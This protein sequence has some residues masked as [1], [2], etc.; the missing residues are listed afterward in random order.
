MTNQHQ[1]L[2]LGRETNGEKLRDGLVQEAPP[3]K[4]LSQ[5]TAGIAPMLSDL[6]TVIGGQAGVLLK[7]AESDATAQEPLQQICA[8]ADKAGSLLRQLQIFSGQQTA[9]VENTQL[10]GLI[11]ENVGGLHRLLG[12]GMTV[13][14]HLAD[15]LPTVEIDRT[16]LEQLLLILTLNAV[17]AMP[18]GGRL[19]IQTEALNIT[20]LVAKDHPGSRP[21]QFVVLS[22]Q[23]SG[24]GIAPE[25]LPRIFE[26]FFTT[27]PVGRSVGLGLAT[28]SGIV[29]LHQGWIEV[30]NT[31]DG[32]TRFQVMLPA[33][34][35]TAAL[36]TRLPEAT[37]QSS[38]NLTVLLV[39]DEAPVREFAAFVL[40]GQGCRVLQAV[41]GLDALEVWQ[42]HGSR[43]RLLLTDVVLED[44]MNG[45]ELAIN[46]R[47]ENPDLK[48]ICTT[49]LQREE[50]E[51]FP[52][53][54][55]G[56]HYLQKPYRFETLVMALR[57]ALEGT[58]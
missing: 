3:M 10:N 7:S 41:S 27:K 45:M 18:V 28:A 11:E 44:D 23:D 56:Y 1:S 43:I 49:G 36:K 4:A 39:E 31:H 47:A 32:G 34:Q 29:R 33:A 52:E 58:V 46:L 53:L 2:P 5:I 30:K 35:A 40:R 42:W 38:G 17:E 15:N 51:D 6:L 48:V 8:A 12:K 24:H 37:E 57:E 50:L 9:H 25:I 16:M 20:E 55:G 14:Y 19:Q 21:G 22:V 54:E 13:E 26:P